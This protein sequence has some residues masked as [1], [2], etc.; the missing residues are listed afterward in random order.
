MTFLLCTVLLVFIACKKQ[1]GFGGNASISG[2][3]HAQH[4]NST[5]TSLLSEYPVAD[6]D[7]YIIPDGYVSPEDKIATNYEGKF[8]FRYLYPG[9]YTIYA[10]SKD[11]TMPLNGQPTQVIREVEI[12]KINET[13]E[14]DSMVIFE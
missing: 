8:E 10:Y 3:V 6:Y 14:V 13:V 1:A 5:F 11:S 12:K 4:F 2:K 9:K 7:V